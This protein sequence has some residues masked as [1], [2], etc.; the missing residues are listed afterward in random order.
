MLKNTKKIDTYPLIRTAAAIG[1]ALVLATILIFAVSDNPIESL[2]AFLLGP[3]ESKRDFF[4]IFVKLVPYLLTGA[5][6]N[7]MHRSGLFNLGADG[8]LYM[9]AIVATAVATRVQLPNIIH[10]TVLILAAALV[11][12]LIGML[13]AI[14][15]SKFGANEIVT[16]LMSNYLFYFFGLW[17][18]YTFLVDPMNGS[19][20]D[21]IPETAKLPLLVSGTRL[22][23]GFVIMIVIFIAMYFLIEKS[24]MGNQLLVIGANKNFAKYAG[25]S[26]ASTV[27]LS[28][29]IGGALAGAAGAI[30]IVGLFPRF[31]WITQVT[32]VWDGLLV[33]MLANRKMANI[34]LA[35]LFLA[36]IRNGA[37]IMARTTGVSD[38]IVPI[39]QAIIIL[40]I[41]SDRFLYGIKKKREEK[42]AYENDKKLSD[43]E[44]NEAATAAAQ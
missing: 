13:P 25:L 12:G 11:G 42:A 7:F 16:S 15:K 41:A 4:G 34:P 3:F 17:I 28:Q 44:Q 6:V 10:Q 9:G 22:H 32:Y 24:K 36:F 14:F 5:A 30:E 21:L 20:S 19:Q 40:L 23:W 29:F 37:D 18:F 27:L 8:A 35:A 31:S 39:I 2:Q 1:L 26:V 38:Q 43:E 33:N